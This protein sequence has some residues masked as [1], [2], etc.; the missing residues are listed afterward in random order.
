MNKNWICDGWGGV[1]RGVFRFLEFY[2]L[3]NKKIWINVKSSKLGE[4]FI[5]MQ[6]LQLNSEEARITNKVPQN[7]KERS[8]NHKS[9]NQK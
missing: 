1:G 5:R 9:Q 6:H 4:K 2:L 7:H 3:R 8:K